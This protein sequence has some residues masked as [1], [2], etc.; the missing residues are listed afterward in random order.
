MTRPVPNP[1]RFIQC[2]SPADLQREIETDTRI[3]WAQV[4]IDAGEV[5]QAQSILT[6]I[7][8]PRR[9]ALKLVRA[10]A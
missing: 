7:D 6:E 5:E 1:T 10:A 9:A 3:R 8:A 2:A 4:L